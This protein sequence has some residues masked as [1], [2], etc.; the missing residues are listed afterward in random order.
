MREKERDYLYFLPVTGYPLEWSTLFYIYAVL[1]SNN[2]M[3]NKVPEFNIISFTGCF[4][5]G[6]TLAG[7]E[8]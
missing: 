4:V 2:W 5:K 1:L 6:N 7:R 8:R 3:K